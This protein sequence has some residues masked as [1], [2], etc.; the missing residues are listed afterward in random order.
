MTECRAARRVL[1]WLLGLS[2]TSLF[3]APISWRRTQPSPTRASLW[4]TA[5]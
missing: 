2:V 1:R 4:A 3:A 5:Q